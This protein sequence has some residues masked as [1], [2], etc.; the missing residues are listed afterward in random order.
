MPPASAAEIPMVHSKKQVL[1]TTPS[2]SDDAMSSSIMSESDAGDTTEDV[3]LLNKRCVIVH[4]T[5]QKVCTYAK[6]NS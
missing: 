4:N 3:L 5:L 6:K 2:A 1:L